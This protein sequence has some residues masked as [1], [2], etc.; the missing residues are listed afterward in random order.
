MIQPSFGKE[1]LIATLWSFPAFRDLQ[2]ADLVALCEDATVLEFVPGQVVFEQ[3]DPASSALL[4]LQGRLVAKV[5]GGA[6]EARVGECRPGEIVGESA[7]LGREQRR[8]ATVFASLHTHCMLIGSDLL[9]VNNDQAAM[10]LEQ[11]LIATFTR[12]IRKTN[13]A[14]KLFWKANPLDVVIHEEGE[15][16]ITLKSRLR[17]LISGFVR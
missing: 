3:G 10:A 4:V 14:V 12:R 6:E 11:Y 7:L 1:K 16:P 2:E 13:Q 15:A 8:N 9:A 17:A 5:Q